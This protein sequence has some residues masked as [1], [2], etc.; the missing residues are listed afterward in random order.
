MNDIIIYPY[1]NESI[2]NHEKFISEPFVYIDKYDFVKKEI[3]NLLDLKDNWDGNDAIPVFHRVGEIA[4]D[5][6]KIINYFEDITDIFP[7]PHGTITI[8]W[9]NKQKEKLFLE[10]G[11]NSYSY[12][13]KY[14]NKPP[15]LVDGNDILSDAKILTKD[16]GELF[17]EEIPDFI[18]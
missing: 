4:K 8:E 10:I 5:L 15:K 9:S 13:V 14:N 6:F 1:S 3:D 12:F 7:N 2:L 17:S 18:L 11:V 16:L